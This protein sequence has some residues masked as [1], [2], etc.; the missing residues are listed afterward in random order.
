MTSEEMLV[1]V[2]YNQRLLI[3][4]SMHVGV[5]I[6]SCFLQ[7]IS[8]SVATWR[9]NGTSDHFEAAESSVAAAPALAVG[10]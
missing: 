2:F 1:A 4:D 9:A 7:T 3:F 6:L 8:V 10:R 5:L